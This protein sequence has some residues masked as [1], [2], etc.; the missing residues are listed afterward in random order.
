MAQIKIGNDKVPVSIV[1]YIDGTFLKKGIPIR[2]VYSECSTPYRILYRIRYRVSICRYRIRYL[3]YYSKIVYDIVYDIECIM[4]SD[5]VLAVGCLNNDRSVLAKSYAW[6]PL[7]LL[8]ILKGSA[9]LETNDDWVRHRR[10]ELYHSSMDH[11]IADINELCSKDMY[12]RFADGQVRCSRPFYHLLV[13]DG[14]EVGAA[15]MCDV[16]QCPVCTCPHSELDRTDVTYPYRN[17]ESVKAAVK[18]AQEAHLDEDGQVLD[19]H[20][21]KVRK[22]VLMYH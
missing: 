14:Q 11:I 9:C 10:M 22:A 6:R 15:L 19:G 13:M 5:S 3:L 4:E 1:L 8:P 7:A 16:N 21:A 12:L 18:E 2:P 17:M 20:N